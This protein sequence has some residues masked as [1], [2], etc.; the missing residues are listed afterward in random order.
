MALRINYFRWEWAGFCTEWEIK[1]VSDAGVKIAGTVALVTGAN[2]GIGRSFVRNLLERGAEK[3]YACLRDTSLTESVKELDRERVIPVKLDV[4]DAA[5]ITAARIKCPD[6]KILVNNAGVGTDHGFLS[7]PNMGEM[8]RMFDVNFLGQVRMARAFSSVLR[9]N[10][11]GAVISMAS[12]NALI[13]CKKY[14]VFSAIE[15]AVLSFAQS[16]RAELSDHGTQVTCVMPGFVNTNMFDSP[17]PESAPD[18]VAALALDG[19]EAGVL[20]VFPDALSQRIQEAVL[21]RGREAMDMPCQLFDEIV[22]TLKP[23]PAADLSAP[24][25]A[26]SSPEPAES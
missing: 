14:P 1:S 22:A 24:E 11:G 10:G 19:L 3:V 23:E 26:V 15:H 9:N 5:T 4:T 2:R 18:Q 13:N 7:A 20:N 6:V 17:Y 12:A 16:L 25:A 21:Q 8:E